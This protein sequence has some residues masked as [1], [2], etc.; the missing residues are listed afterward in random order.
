MNRGISA[1]QTTIPLAI[2][3]NSQALGKS[4]TFQIEHGLAGVCVFLIERSARLQAESRS[5]SPLAHNRQA[6]FILDRPGS[7]IQAKPP[8]VLT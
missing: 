8:E 7:T 5:P 1:R 2:R 6:A 3:P 4:R